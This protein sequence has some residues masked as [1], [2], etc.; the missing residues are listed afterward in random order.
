MIDETEKT[1]AS[2]DAPTWGLENPPGVRLPDS[3]FS[4]GN[5]VSVGGE[6]K[7]QG[8]FLQLEFKA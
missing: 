2:C 8:A 4:N 7:V 3:G 6:G 5:G 1:A